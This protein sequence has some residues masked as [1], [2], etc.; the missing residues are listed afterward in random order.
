MEINDPENYR[1]IHHL[2]PLWW[3]GLP[4]V[5][6]LH[7]RPKWIDGVAGP[8]VAELLE[9]SAPGRLASTAWTPWRRRTTR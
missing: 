6:E 2:R 9:A 8:P 7:S 1:D 4:L 5:V 3:P